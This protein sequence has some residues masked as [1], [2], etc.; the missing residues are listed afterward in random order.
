[1]RFWT[2]FKQKVEKVL[3]AE[4]DEEKV[5]TSF[6]NSRSEGANGTGDPSK[7][8]F[9]IAQIMGFMGSTK[10]LYCRESYITGW[11]CS[12][13]CLIN[14]EHLL[15]LICKEIDTKDMFNILYG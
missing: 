9:S 5:G 1:M 4:E 10:V 7:L 8:G 14:F 6:H 12:Y 3:V 11:M 2:T 15:H 13:P